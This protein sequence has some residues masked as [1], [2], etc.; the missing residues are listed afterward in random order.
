MH[1]LVE[2]LVEEGRRQ[3]FKQGLRQTIIIFVE[4]M[5]EVGVNDDVILKKV[6]EKFGLSE[7]EGKSYI[8]Q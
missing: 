3:G 1:G 6:I 2:S 5:R 7:E 4:V 8:Q